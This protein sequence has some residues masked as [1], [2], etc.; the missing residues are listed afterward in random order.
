MTEERKLARRTA[1]YVSAVEEA[2]AAMNGA[3]RE[4]VLEDV[5]DHIHAALQDRA[6]SPTL[7]HLEAVLSELGSPESYA[8]ELQAQMTPARGISGISEP[9]EPARLC[10][11][12]AVGLAWSILF[13]VVAV[14]AL[15]VTR[16]V[17][18][19]ETMDLAQRAYIGI[20]WLAL[21]GVLGGPLMSALAISKIRASLG[22]LYGLGPA[23]LGLYLLPLAAMDLFIF[24]AV[25]SILASSFGVSLEMANGLAL[26]AVLLAFYWNVR[27]LRGSI[28]RLNEPRPE[29]A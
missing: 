11:Q 29:Y 8:A 25:G 22:H 18:E 13:L 7:E 23:V 3:D 1:V 10:K 6:A 20:A 2:L 28:K 14:P 17:A 4:A 19:G 26:V 16:A 27:I 12:A 24:I 9:T 15:L 5:E 21:A